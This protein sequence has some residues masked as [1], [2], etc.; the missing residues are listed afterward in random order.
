MTPAYDG[1]AGQW[2]S[3]EGGTMTA[4]TNTPTTAGTAKDEADIRRLFDRWAEA[5][6]S[7][8]IEGSLHGYSTDVLAFDLINPLRYVGLNELRSRLADWFA[9]FAG[10]IGYE[11]RDLSITACRDAAFGHSLNHVDGTTTA[12]RKIDMWWRATVCFRKIDGEWMVT[13]SHTSVPF[14]METGEA[15]LDLEP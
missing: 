12:G 14:D 8:D 1:G 10:S 9:S 4:A 6:R 3:S 2:A 7:K 13:H 5:V 11:N 15:S